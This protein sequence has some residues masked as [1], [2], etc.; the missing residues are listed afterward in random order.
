M[1]CKLPRK[2]LYPTHRWCILWKPCPRWSILQSIWK[3]LELWY[4]QSKEA[5]SIEPFTQISIR[6]HTPQTCQFSMFLTVHSSSGNATKK[7]KNITYGDDITAYISFLWCSEGVGRVG[8]VGIVR[9]ISHSML[10][11]Q[12][13]V[14]SKELGRIISGQSNHSVLD[15]LMNGVAVQNLQVQKQPWNVC[16]QCYQRWEVL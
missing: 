9:M 11:L 12:F 5:L 10:P 16:F 3:D 4:V 2:V 15:V 1:I 8:V 14:L 13:E 7:K 6:R